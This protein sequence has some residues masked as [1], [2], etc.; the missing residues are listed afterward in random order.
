MTLI[1]HHGSHLERKL[2]EMYLLNRGYSSWSEYLLQLD[3][4]II[5]VSMHEWDTY[6]EFDS[7]QRMT[8]FIL[9]WA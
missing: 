3:P 5:Q 4:S 1:I 6:V 7:D 2:Y 9:K 8:W